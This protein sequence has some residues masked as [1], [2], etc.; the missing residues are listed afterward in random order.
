MSI[1]DASITAQPQEAELVARLRAEAAAEFA[2]HP[3]W[4]QADLIRNYVF[5][6]LHAERAK[7]NLH[8]Y[9]I[10]KGKWMPANVW[11]G[12]TIVNQAEADRDIPKLLATPAAKRFLSMEP[13]LGPIDLRAI[14][15]T[16]DG[17]DLRLDSLSG[18]SRHTWH[19]E[20]AGLGYDP[21]PYGMIDSYKPRLDW[22]I[23][24]G[25]SGAGARPIPDGAAQS[26]VDQCIAAH[27]AV[28]VKRR[29]ARPTAHHRASP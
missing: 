21:G 20:F 8:A 17:Y 26:I 24:G 7:P 14:P 12:A 18:I 16:V 22:I 2:G 6:R 19:S 10:R 28:F 15:V 9:R 11:L 25:E 1:S 5:L 23:V 3:D 29:A 13:L 4:A 27:V